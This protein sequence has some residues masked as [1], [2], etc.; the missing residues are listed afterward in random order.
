[1]LILEPAQSANLRYSF[2]LWILILSALTG[3]A[4]T[5]NSMVFTKLNSKNGLLT[6]VVLQ[7]VQDAKGFLWIATE[8]GLQR[9][10]GNH[11]TNYHHIPGDSSS[12]PDNFINRLFVDSKGRLWVISGTHIAQYNPEKNNFRTIRT[13]EQVRFIKKILEDHNGKI[14]V[15]TVTRE[16]Y[17]FDETR[18]GF[19]E[20]YPLPALPG[21]FTVDNM[22]PTLEKDVYWLTTSTGAVKLNMNP[23]S[24][25]SAEGGSGSLY[26]DPKIS[27]IKQTRYPY[28]D[29]SNS[30]WFVSFV[31]FKGLP[32]LYNFND[33][34]GQLRVWD[35]V[36]N[37]ITNVSHEIWGIRQQ[38]NG[39]TW[40]YGPSILAY[41]DT[42]TGKFVHIKSS[43]GKENG[44]EY[45][46]VVDLF[47]DRENNLWIS[48][49][50][51]L[52]R[53]NLSQQYFQYLPVQRMADTG[54]IDEHVTAILPVSD[55]ETW[56]GT[57]GKGVFSY[58]HHWKPIPNALMQGRPALANM[59]VICMI[60]TRSGDIWIGQRD[61]SILVYHP[62]T[63]LVEKFSLSA[64][65][66]ESVRQ[67]LEDRKGNIWIGTN[68]GGLLTLEKGRWRDSLHSIHW[69][70][71]N[72]LSPVTRLYED[73]QGM[74]WIGTMSD[75]LYKR[76]PD[77]YKV[78]AHYVQATVKEK[79]LGSMAANDMLQYDD[80][81]LLIASQGISILN[82]RTNRFRYFGPA[83]GLPS[84]RTL[85]L[86]KDQQGK[87]WVITVSNIY[88]FNLE[89]GL[90]IQYNRSNGLINSNFE[91]AS[92]ALLP[93]NQIVLG[94]FH[95]F[96]VFD[97]G[98]ATDTTLLPNVLL[99][100]L[101]LLDQPVSIDSAL[102]KGNILT[103][104]Y[105]KSSLVIEFS[106]LSYS[107]HPTVQYMLEG[108]DRDWITAT[109]M[110]AS[111]PFLPPGTYAFKV[112]AIHEVGLIGDTVTLMTVRVQR[113]FWKSWI[114][115]VILLLAL[116]AFLYWQDRKRIRRK[117]YILR[118]RSQLATSLHEEVNTALGN[119][120]ILSEVASMKADYDLEK[121]KM[122]IKQ[123]NHRSRHMIVAMND[124]LWSIDPANDNMPKTVE[125]LQEYVHGLNAE[126]G[127]QYTLDMKHAIHSIEL[128]MPNRYYTFCLFRSYVDL[129]V[130]LGVKQA[131][132]EIDAHKSELCFVLRFPFAEITHADFEQSMG[133]EPIANRMEDLGGQFHFSKSGAFS[134]LE[135]DIP[136]RRN[137]SV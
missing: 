49:N 106:T 80:S 53:L 99:T 44:I 115:Y 75:G 121:S 42:T 90:P 102:Q 64:V 54:R 87:L 117:E 104:P 36:T 40:I 39:M 120:S 55:R 50:K 34:T 95:D 107:K 97:L 5:P 7:S 4:Q 84:E 15:V 25:L 69:L 67:L 20:K 76:H 35:S 136:L 57:R 66:G 9:Y 88:Q 86:I 22:A 29:R 59:E 111:Y 38:R 109:E 28:V 73:R 94:T 92:H 132:I 21:H 131:E 91:I 16:V 126:L 123:I 96:L 65:G 118:M 103:L 63:D 85:N 124:M 93:G 23:A 114:F 127:V 112:R 108:V 119:I 51:G 56:I 70:D 71:T 129:L 81:T 72:S 116:L 46:Y 3:Q 18:M 128:E 113:P 58:D 74:I 37:P 14:L 101:R 45:D 60:K 32:A 110:K 79:G 105:D 8:N 43:P 134:R 19:F 41:L 48:S 27:G 61:G 31:P 62:A 89:R 98:K 82:T 13:G 77:S 137:G 12:I 30:L 17:F 10:D 47:E 135:T 26:Q 100:G 130:E 133:K 33:K 52:Y 24:G 78:L 1:M 11:F 122:Y 83:D 6:D 68:A 125:R 2:F